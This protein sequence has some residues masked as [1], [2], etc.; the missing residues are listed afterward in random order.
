MVLAKRFGMPAILLTVSAN[1]VPKYVACRCRGTMKPSLNLIDHV[2]LLGVTFTHIFG[3]PGAYFNKKIQAQFLSNICLKRLYSFMMSK[4]NVVR[5][6][7]FK[8]FESKQRRTKGS[9]VGGMAPF[10]FA[11]Q[12]WP[13]VPGADQGSEG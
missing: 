12:A 1:I 13:E 4:K 6:K 7:D 2:F 8:K 10:F 3:S 11:T 9:V 5:I